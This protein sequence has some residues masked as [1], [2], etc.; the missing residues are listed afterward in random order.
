MLGAK[1]GWEGRPREGL[2]LCGWRT[3]KGGDARSMP[4]DVTNHRVSGTDAIHGMYVRLLKEAKVLLDLTLARA[5][6]MAEPK[7]ATSEGTAT[8]GLK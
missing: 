7:K 1:M 2:Q 5:L 3:V 6:P 4:I 8:L